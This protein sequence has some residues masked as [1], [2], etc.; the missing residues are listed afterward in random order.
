MKVTDDNKH[1][2]C[3]RLPIVMGAAHPKAVSKNEL[4]QE[5]IDKKNGSWVEPEQ[6]NYSKYT[7]YFEQAIQKIVLDDFPTLKFKKGANEKPYLAVHAPLGCS[8][9]D[10]AIAKEPIQVTDPNGQTFTM[11]GD[12]LVEYK[13]TSVVEDQLPL[14]KGPIQV[15]GQMLCTHTSKALVVVFNIRTWQIQYWPIFENKELQSAIQE[16]VRDFW[17]RRENE[18]YYDPQKPGDYNLIYT[19]PSDEPKDLSGNNAI[20][21]A[22]HT[23]TEGN[24]EIK[25]GKLKV[26]QS[27]DIIKQ[28]MGDHVF[29]LF[30]NFKISWP[31]RNYKAKPE[32]VVPA[33]EAYSKRSST[34]QIK[35]SDE[36][37]ES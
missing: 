11:Q 4:L 15:Q 28:A 19:N 26:E 20:G 36:K 9:D 27:Q 33:Q 18:E 14:Y 17:K 8:I 6:N 23:W 5:F 3:S 35:E 30:N 2:T 13:T 29:G 25:S 12:I 1:F 16:V 34:I 7:D 21:A 32:K 31:V 22:I 37:K 24:N 10:W